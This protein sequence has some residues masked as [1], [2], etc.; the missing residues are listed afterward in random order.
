MPA[1]DEGGGVVSQ[2]DG[3]LP[4]TGMTKTPAGVDDPLLMGAFVSCLY[5]SLKEKNVLEAFRKDTGLDVMRA[6]P[7][8]AV[9]QMVLRATGYQAEV[10]AKF[11]D[12]VAENVWGLERVDDNEATTVEAEYP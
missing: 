6:V 10:F 9:D 5:A 8:S 7:R 12:W 3:R 1:G 4:V 11:A 2:I